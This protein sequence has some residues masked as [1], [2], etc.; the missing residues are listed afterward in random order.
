V[1]VL[2]WCALF[3]LFALSVLSLSHPLPLSHFAP[4]LSLSLSLSLLLVC[5]STATCD[6]PD[7]T[8]LTRPDKS[9][10]PGCVCQEGYVRNKKGVC[11]PVD[12]CPP[13][14]PVCLKEDNEVYSECVLDKW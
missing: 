14:P 12:K 6:N 4:F 13:P 3:V 10:E 2:A 1:N 11:I 5:P 8:C 7:G 9:C